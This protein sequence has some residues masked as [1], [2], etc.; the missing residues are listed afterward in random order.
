M[1]IEKHSVITNIILRTRK[2]G[3]ISFDCEYKM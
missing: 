1:D 3:N 2:V